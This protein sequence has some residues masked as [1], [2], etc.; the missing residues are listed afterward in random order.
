M[1]EFTTFQTTRVLLTRNSDIPYEKAPC[2]VSK[3]TI[4]SQ[5][6]LWPKGI[7]FRQNWHCF[8][9]RHFL[10]RADMPYFYRLHTPSQVSV[11]PSKGRS[12]YHG[13]NVLPLPQTMGLTSA[14]QTMD[15][16]VTSWTMNLTPSQPEGPGMKDRRKDWW[17]R[18]TC[19]ILCLDGP[20]KKVGPR[21]PP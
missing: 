8:G 13:S 21:P 20:V 3:L 12:V 1:A 19:L 18:M 14:P 17:G 4:V 9:S 6:K 7:N 5:K 15:L 2:L 16:I 11:I 10:A